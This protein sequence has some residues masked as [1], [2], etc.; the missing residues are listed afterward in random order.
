MDNLSQD[1]VNNGGDDIFDR[2]KQWSDVR[3]KKRKTRS[4]KDSGSD[5]FDRYKT[6]TTDDKLSV[7][8]TQSNS[9][10]AFISKL[11][12]KI[13][14]CLQISENV[15]NMRT[16]IDEHESRILLLEYKSHDLE[17][18]SRCK[19]LLF[20]GFREERDEN[21]TSKICNFILDKLEIVADVCIDRAHRLCRYKHGSNRPI[22]SHSDISP[23]PSLSYL[24]PI[25]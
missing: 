15:N 3:S 19:N 1:G 18:R 10:S 5:L 20:I 24:V 13:D 25:N 12:E 8:F 21:C 14:K 7:L 11:D 4:S 2:T 17:A 22:M 16:C 23:I 9:Q 6:L